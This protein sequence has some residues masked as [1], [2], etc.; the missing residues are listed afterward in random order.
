M[1][2]WGR[3]RNGDVGLDGEVGVGG[4]LSAAV[5]VSERQLVERASAFFIVIAP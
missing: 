2:S 4:E 1:G 5:P 3:R